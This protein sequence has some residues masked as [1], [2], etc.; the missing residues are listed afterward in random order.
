MEPC[1]RR[2]AVPGKRQR[3]RA[4][5][6]DEIGLL[7]EG[8]NRLGFDL[9][10]RTYFEDLGP[11]G[12]D[13]LSTGDANLLFRLFQSDRSLWRIGVGMPWLEF[14]GDVDIGYNFTTSADFFPLR[15]WIVSFEGDAGKLGHAT[16][17]HGRSTIGF[18]LR[19]TE[20]YTGIDHLKIED[21]DVTSLVTGVRTWW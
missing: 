21:T 9:T 1:V 5:A 16:L 2:I 12:H 19:H 8:E 11:Q 4:L 14:E 17:L 20:L 7:V 13:D 18:N 15:P 10:W 3:D 6:F